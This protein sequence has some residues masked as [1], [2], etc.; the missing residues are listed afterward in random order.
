MTDKTILIIGEGEPEDY[1]KNETMLFGRG[2]R[3]C[4][5]EA[6]TRNGDYIRGYTPDLIITTTELSNSVMNR[7]I[8]PMQALK[9]AELI[10]LYD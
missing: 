8:K 7:V 4:V 3:V 1:T 2:D 5:A 9:G 6:D 10:E